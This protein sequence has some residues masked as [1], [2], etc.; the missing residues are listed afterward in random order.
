MQMYRTNPP[1]E[2]MNLYHETS[3]PVHSQFGGMM[4]D[5]C[6]WNNTV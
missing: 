6:T 3:T 5:D 1:S 4:D 2:A